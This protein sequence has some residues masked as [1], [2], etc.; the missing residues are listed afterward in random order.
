MFLANMSQAK[1]LNSLDE[2]TPTVLMPAAIE[3][4][5]PAAAS[6]KTIAW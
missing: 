3:D 1:L 2:P 5:N 4:V 6:S